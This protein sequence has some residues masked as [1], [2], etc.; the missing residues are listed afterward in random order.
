MDTLGSGSPGAGV[1]QDSAR[2]RSREE[3]TTRAERGGA[4]NLNGR[5]V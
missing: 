4:P 5:L 3:R 1:D 2:A